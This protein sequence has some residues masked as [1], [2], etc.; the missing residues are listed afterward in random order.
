MLRI[1]NSRGRQHIFFASL[2]FPAALDS[3]IANPSCLLSLQLPQTRWAI[4]IDVY[5]LHQAF[6]SSSMDLPPMLLS[7]AMENGINQ[8][9]MHISVI[10]RPSLPQQIKIMLPPLP[11]IRHVK[12]AE[13]NLKPIH[14]AMEFGMLIVCAHTHSG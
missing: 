6:I 9:I 5:S 10:L 7:D 13:Y 8:S 11:A 12:A 2:A 4:I 14:L 3:S 1:V